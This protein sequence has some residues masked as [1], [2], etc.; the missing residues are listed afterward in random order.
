MGEMIEELREA[1]DRARV[2]VSHG[3]RRALELAFHR[4]LLQ[5]VGA[6]VAGSDAR[7][8][9]LERD[10]AD[11]RAERE[12]AE[13]RLLFRMRGARSRLADR[14]GKENRT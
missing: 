14:R 1:L 7:L 3:E 9:L 2:R 13:H 10:L 11:L 4:A 8:E 5:R 12:F 6:D